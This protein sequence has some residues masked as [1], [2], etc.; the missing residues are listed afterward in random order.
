MSFQLKL[1][2]YEKSR[3]EKGIAKRQK[4]KNMKKNNKSRVTTNKIGNKREKKRKKLGQ[5]T[6]L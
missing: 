1:K 2:S 5:R 4:A 6:Y 3:N